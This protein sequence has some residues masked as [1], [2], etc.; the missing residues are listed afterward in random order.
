MDDAL[1]MDKEEL[2]DIS[3]ILTEET[4]I[5]ELV[6][7]ITFEHLL[8]RVFNVKEFNNDQEIEDLEKYDG[9][10]HA[11]DQMRLMCTSLYD[12]VFDAVEGMAIGKELGPV[13]TE[14]YKNLCMEA[15]MERSPIRRASLEKRIRTSFGMFIDIEV[16]SNLLKD[17]QR[18]FELI[19]DAIVSGATAAQ[20]NIL[21]G[22]SVLYAMRH[23]Y[24]LEGFN[25]EIEKSL[26][27]V[28]IGALRDTAMTL[29][30]NCYSAKDFCCDTLVSC[31]QD[32]NYSIGDFTL[33]DGPKNIWPKHSEAPIT[34]PVTATIQGDDG[35]EQMLQICPRVVE[36]FGSINAILN[37]SILPIEL[38]MT[39]VFHLSGKLG[40]MNNYVEG[41]DVVL[42]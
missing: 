21:I 20:E 7:S 30:T 5:G 41:G 17:S 33:R 14:R 35:S 40:F 22:N 36:P 18:K 37:S 15:E 31:V 32:E 3:T 4:G 2:E 25:R 28:I 12:V 8:Y 6:N 13:A 16:G 10:P 11:V 42:S 19:L 9:D 1:R 39:K 29:I 24:K 34:E 26:I 38:A 23:A 27:D